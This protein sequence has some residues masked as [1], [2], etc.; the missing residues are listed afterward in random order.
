MINQRGQAYH[1]AGGEDGVK[2]C[3]Y[4]GTPVAHKVDEVAS[5]TSLR[6]DALFGY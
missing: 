3:R 2:G 4:L 1:I 6:P 5:L